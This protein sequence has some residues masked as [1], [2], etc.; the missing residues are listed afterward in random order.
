[1]CTIFIL[2]HCVKQLWNL[3]DGSIRNEFKGHREAIEACI[4]LPTNHESSLIA[5]ASRD[6]SVRVW[7]MFTKGRTGLDFCVCY[8]M[9]AYTCMCVC[10]YTCMCVCVCVCVCTCV[11]VC[12]CVCVLLNAWLYACIHMCVCVCMYID[13]CACS[14]DYICVFI[15]PILCLLLSTSFLILGDCVSDCLCE[16]NL[17][18]SGPLTSMIAYRDGR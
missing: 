2:F 8:C 17:E 9:H 10:V 16:C 4:F 11:C 15:L 7:D 5:T 13:V 18:G 12:V 1:M 3:A 6:C 14:V